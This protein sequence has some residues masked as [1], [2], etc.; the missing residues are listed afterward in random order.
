MSSGN[1]KVNPD[2]PDEYSVEL[3]DGEVLH[4]GRRPAPGGVKKLILPYP[5]VSGQ[6][7]EIRC[8]AAGWTIM[9]RNSTNGTSIN[10]RSCNSGEE[11]PLKAGDEVR[12]AQYQLRVFPPQSNNIELDTEDGEEDSQDRTQ[13]SIKFMNATILVGDIKKFT[14]LMERY[15]TS[16]EVVM[17]A[18]QRVFESLNDEINNNFGQ[19]EKIAG[20]AIM[21]YWAGDSSSEGA[22]LPAYQACQTALKLR[23]VIARIS[24]DSRIWPFDDY[25]LAL[26][27]ALATGPV[28][29]GSLG[30][31]AG[32]PAVLGDTANLVFRLE[33]LIGDDRPGD[34]IVDGNTFTLSNDRCNFEYM[35]S[36]NIKGKT[37]AVEVYRLLSTRN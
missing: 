16:P 29:A 9:D 7:A 18:A 33:K 6:H 31:S 34:I 10:G 17:G 15:A 20:D 28:A 13:Y 21:A 4:I 36:Y 37:K 26:D 2:T 12:I 30:H 22:R 27:I 14:T 5:E 19:L 35:G 24:K 1:I 11:Y 32:N 25:P 8:A 23:E 3:N